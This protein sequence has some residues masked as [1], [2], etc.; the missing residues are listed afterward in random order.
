MLIAPTELTF[1][2]NRHNVALDIL[3]IILH[4]IPI[5]ITPTVLAELDSGHLPVIC[6][7]KLQRNNCTIKPRDDTKDNHSSQ[8]HTFSRLKTP[9]KNRHFNRT[10]KSSVSHVPTYLYSGQQGRIT[11]GQSQNETK[12]K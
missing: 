6:E 7:M 1:Y 8:S 2:S 12:T 3:D 5:D 11:Q 4:D 10:Q 9:T